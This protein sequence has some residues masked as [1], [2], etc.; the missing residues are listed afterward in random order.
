MRASIQKQLLRAIGGRLTLLNALV[1]CGILLGLVG[2]LYGV[3][4]ITTD[5][6]LNQ[7]LTQA[8]Q[9]EQ[10]EDLVQTIKAG[11][12]LIDPPRPFLPT[13]QQAFFLLVDTRGS[14]YE[15]ATTRVAGLPDRAAVQAALSTGVPDKREVTLEGMHLRLWTV[16]I[17]DQVGRSVGAIQ[18]YVSLQ[19]R[20]S[21][22]ARL[23]IVMSAGCAVGLLLSLLA[24]HFLARRALVP[25]WRAFEQQDQF[26][27]DASHELRAPLTLLQADVE[28]LQRALRPLALT[29][30]VWAGALVGSKD[31]EDANAFLVLRQEDAEILEE[32]VEEIGH[33]KHLLADLL[34]LARY[35]AGV[36]TRPQEIVSLHPVLTRLAERLQSQLTQAHLTFHVVLPKDPQMLLVVGDAP[37][38]QRLLLILL[39]NAISYTPKG[40]HIWLQAEVCSSKHLQISVRDTGRGI[41]SGDLPG[42]FTRFSR[43]DTARTP[44]SG[45]AG[46]PGASGVGLGLAIAHAIVEQHGGQITASSPGVDRGSTFTILLRRGPTDTRLLA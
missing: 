32:V 13:P 40:G 12:P 37:A 22:L 5:A 20:E 45:E 10:A 36:H 4:A 44:H 34:T 2:V 39:T 3:E 27:A 33:M 11:R 43:A 31:N 6:A 35:D 46:T 28:V 18:A 30:S 26:V 38:L 19:G 9:Q 1:L 21:E 41:A 14:I 42:L 16:P 17:Y 29:E 23:A 24:A 7:L 8:V 15:G 25:I